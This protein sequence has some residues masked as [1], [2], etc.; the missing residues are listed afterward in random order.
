[1]FVPSLSTMKL[2]SSPVRNSSITRRGAEW[3]N[4]GI[5]F[6]RGLGDDYAFAGGEPVGLDARPESRM[7]A[8]CAQASSAVSDSLESRAVGIPRR[9]T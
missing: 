6:V 2:T 4:G 3:S 1:M 9:R 8:K 7:S 5:R